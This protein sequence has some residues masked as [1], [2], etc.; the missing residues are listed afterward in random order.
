MTASKRETVQGR[1]FFGVNRFFNAFLIASFW[2]VLLSEPGH[3]QS[4]SRYDHGEWEV[5]IFGSG[6]FMG[7]GIYQTPVE[8]SDESSS[9]SV[10]LSYGSG[11][12]VG[13]RITN[14]L[15]RHWG[16]T[17]EYGVSNQ[18][19][20]FTNLSDSIP[21]LGLGQAIHRFAYEAVYYPRDRYYGLRP[22]VFAGPGVSLFH[23]KGS[24]KDSAM[25]QGIRLSDP[26][27]FTMNWGGG[28]KYLLQKRIATSVQFSD[29]IS[30]VP[31]YGLPEAGKVV[32]GVYVPGFR[33]EGTLH[34][35]LIS[36]GVIFE[37][38]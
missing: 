30:G 7:D 14:N 3:A 20:T 29:A 27:K 25:S 37:W 38:R 35:W 15:S 5:S 32:S 24:S 33:P 28:A 9:R 16:T 8:P 18:P 31:G 23:I 13:V 21:S 22:Y 1:S 6:S 36:V 12:Q 4:A 10:G 2:G 17:F 11:A 34:N 19:I 26:W